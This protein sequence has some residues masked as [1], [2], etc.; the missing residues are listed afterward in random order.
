MTKTAGKSLFFGMLAAW[1]ALGAAVMLCLL[2]IPAIAAGSGQG[3]SMNT[4]LEQGK[5]GAVTVERM[6]G[7]VA[8]ANKA[9]EKVQEEADEAAVV[10]KALAKARKDSSST[11]YFIA[12]DLTAKRTMVFKWEGDDWA[13]KKNWVCSVGAPESPTVVGGF[14][15]ADR[16]ESF[17]QDGYTCY[18]YT[19]FDGPYLFHSVKYVEGTYEIEDG[20]LGEAVSEGCVRLDIKNAQWIHDKIPS[21]TRV[22]TYE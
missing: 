11:D 18:F 16:G 4:P 8:D 19:Q 5:L 6:Q 12:V 15:V 20:R 22:V 3:A 21:G 9:V 13:L 7:I 2:A 10:E 14:K 17:S 1:V